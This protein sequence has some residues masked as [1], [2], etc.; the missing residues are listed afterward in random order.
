MLQDDARTNHHP[1]QLALSQRLDRVTVAL[2]EL[3]PGQMEIVITEALLRTG[4]GPRW[5]AC[6]LGQIARQM[7]EMA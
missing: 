4:R 5:A 2:A 1:G 6:H 7:D 3:D